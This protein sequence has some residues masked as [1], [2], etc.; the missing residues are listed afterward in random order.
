MDTFDLPVDLSVIVPVL[1]EVGVIGAF[2]RKLASQRG[3][4]FQVIV[5]DGGSNDGTLQEVSELRHNL[6][7]S[8]I[9]L[10]E[11]KGRARQMNAGARCSCGRY[12]LFL[13]ADSSFTDPCA[14]AKA[15]ACLREAEHA[16]GNGNVAA[17]FS[18]RFSR[19]NDHC[20][21]FYY[22]AE[23]KAR[24][25]RPGCTHGDQGFLVN[26]DLFAKAGCFDQS[27]GVMEGTRF[28]E[29]VRAI[30]QWLLIPVEIVTSARRFETEGHLQRQVLNL[31]M[32]TLDTVGRQDFIC[33]MP[34]LYAEQNMTRRLRLFPFLNR[35]HALT[36][37]LN[38][39][40][41]KIFW[42]SV[43]SYVCNNAWQIPFY[44]DVRRS[45]RRGQA[46]GQGKTPCLD[47]YD[48]HL[49]KLFLSRIVALPAAGLSFISF[50]G[51]RFVTRMMNR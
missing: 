2:L 7:Y 25:D 6:P 37:K 33:E 51:V 14:L 28:A 36:R 9:L 38:G 20:C 32:M 49:Q 5:C 29:T 4:A 26:R 46:A 50:H 47:G 41:R 35:I 22:F 17:R 8:L 24:L 3:I 40:E 19:D 12:L 27:C 21:F 23:C 16:S 34:P 43:G 44:F 39:R 42:L 15:C 30:G 11:E 45:F 18:L 1:N 48:R 31:I 13:H 10:G